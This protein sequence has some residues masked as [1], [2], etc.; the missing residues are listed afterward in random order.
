[1]LLDLKEVFL[2]DGKRLVQNCSV[3]MS[4]MEI[5][6]VKPFVSPVMVNAVADNRAGIVKITC[7]ADFTYSRP[8]DRC[9]T[10]TAK[11]MSM[12]FVHPLV[13]SLSGDHNDDYIETP[14]YT[15]E[16]DDLIIADVLLEI[17]SKHLCSEDC[18]GLCPICGTDLNRTTC[19]CDSSHIDSRLEIL[20][21][22]ID[23]D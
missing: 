7:K 23:N 5:N 19:S 21:Q 2:N 14:D 3:D 20:K 9:T 10:D 1:M 22:L 8:C 6:G 17:P 12:T 4:D 13:V 11:D 18:K 15:L 16:L